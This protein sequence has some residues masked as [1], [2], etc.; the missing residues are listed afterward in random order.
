MWTTLAM[1]E[2]N[3]QL[4]G[5]TW[6]SIHVFTVLTC[7]YHHLCG[8]SSHYPLHIFQKKYT[9]FVFHLFTAH[10]PVLFVFERG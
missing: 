9:S 5:M 4:I 6:A 7:Y 10:M 1:G 3:K 8:L 2:L